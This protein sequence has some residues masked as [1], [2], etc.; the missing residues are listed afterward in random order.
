MQLPIDVKAVLET[1][2]N[3]EEAAKT[4]LSVTLYIDDT[5]DA[6][7]IS[8]VRALFADAAANVRVSIGYL[9]ERPTV[10]GG[11][12]D[13]SVIVAG[14]S[15]IIGAQAHETRVSGSPTMVVTCS[16]DHVRATAD[17]A[18]YAIPVGDMLAPDTPAPAFEGTPPAVLED[19]AREP[20]AFDA[21]ADRTLKLRMGRW[22][23][24]ACSDKKLP[25]ALAFPFVR[26]PLALE[27][28]NA[29][30]MQNAAVGAVAFIPGADMPVMTLNQ[31][32]MLLQIATAYGQPMNINRVKELAAVVGGAF[33]LRGA[34]RQVAGIVPGLG[35]A[36]KGAIG[37]AGT[38]AM[39]HAALEYFES[40]GNAEGLATLA[41]KTGV[42]TVGSVAK[43]A[44]SV[45]DD[46]IAATAKSVLSNVSTGAVKAAAGTAKDSLKQVIG[47]VG[48]AIT[49][50]LSD[51]MGSDAATAAMGI[52]TSGASTVASKAGGAAKTIASAITGKLGGAR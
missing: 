12:D 38:E 14:E 48:P 7:L 25:F 39:G 32:K 46:G 43:T 23:V 41:A 42:R 1:A 6:A 44:K 8:F 27:A 5:A 16:P 51:K 9:G 17:A 3:L 20:I 4:P 35:W 52:F 13:V 26:R 45:S 10:P 24:A 21:E 11:R 22:V 34:A 37:F 36:V 15:P 30:S 50:G 2:S 47:Q 28:V 33:L 18:G 31:A 49:D 19:E 40:G 29:T